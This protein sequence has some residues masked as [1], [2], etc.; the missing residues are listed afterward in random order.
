MIRPAILV[1]PLVLEKFPVS[2][3]MTRV[4]RLIL[5]ALSVP[6]GCTAPRH[7]PVPTSLAASYPQ[8]DLAN[9]GEYKAVPPEYIQRLQGSSA[10]SSYAAPERPINI[11]ALSG[12]GKFGA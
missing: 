11:L 3:R 5:V 6:T 7:N 8:A 10:T 1:S 2:R 9:C 4:T 12:G